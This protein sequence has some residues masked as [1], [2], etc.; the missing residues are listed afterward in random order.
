MIILN[1]VMA[2][3][4]NQRTEFNIWDYILSFIYTI[5]HNL[6]LW[7]TKLIAFI[8]S[9]E[10]TPASIIDPLGF[11]IVLTLFFILLTLAKKIAWIILVIGW[12]L[13]LIR[14]LMIVFKIA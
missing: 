11:L 7:G 4:I 5:A 1:F 6:G 13:I 9:L 2:F 14:I 10:T 12:I 3:G 8:F